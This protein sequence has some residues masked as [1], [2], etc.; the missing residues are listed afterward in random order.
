[1]TRR[2]ASKLTKEQYD[3]IWKL[4]AEGV[5]NQYIAKEINVSSNSVAN[6][7]NE[8]RQYLAPK[9]LPKPKVESEEQ[10][11]EN[12]FEKAGGFFCPDKYLKSYKY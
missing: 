6:I 11:F 2:I 1:M 12:E 10:V 3:I 4:H 5:I 8:N 9:T 7:I